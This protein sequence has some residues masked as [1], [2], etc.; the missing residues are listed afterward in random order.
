M[1]AVDCLAVFGDPGMR[2]EAVGKGDAD[3]EFALAACVGHQGADGESLG[4]AVG[5]G[6]ETSSARD[7]ARDLLGSST[8][9]G[10]GADR[11]LG[12]VQ[13]LERP[14]PQPG[15]V[16]EADDK[17]AGQEPEAGDHGTATISCRACNSD[18]S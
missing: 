2:G 5:A 6:E 7:G 16:G 9:S 14:E 3:M 12:E 15:P 8:G 1:L 18:K 4:E 13:G 17:S 11:R 10:A